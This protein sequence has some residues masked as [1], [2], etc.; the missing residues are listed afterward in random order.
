[1]FL[2]EHCRICCKKLRGTK[3]FIRDYQEIFKLFGVDV[4][5]DDA[6]VHP[7]FFCN[8]CY[9]TAK[10]SSLNHPGEPINRVPFQW[11]PHSDDLCSVCDSK[12]KG[13]RP[14]KKEPSGGRPSALHQHI[15]AVAS[16]VP[17][18]K[19]TEVLDCSY[20]E[21]VSCVQCK[22][23]VVKPVEI[24]PCKSLACSS[25][26]LDLVYKK[27]QFCCPGCSHEHESGIDSFSHVSPTVN[28][29]LCDLVVKCTKC[30]KNIRLATLNDNCLH[31]KSM[32]ENITLEEIIQQPLEAEPTNLEK[33]AAASLVTR[34]LHQKGDNIISTTKK[35]NSKC[36]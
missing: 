17:S 23:L 2:D 8:S 36:S 11:A 20:K 14:K 21:H 35:R 16:S 18:S 19:I 34:L 15:Q 13:G 30:N 25:C 3:Y 5:D 22:L 29:I 24:Q 26:C 31:H 6:H 9:L 27:T 28:K 32:N 33:R 4:S 12:C 1:M 10:R 7:E